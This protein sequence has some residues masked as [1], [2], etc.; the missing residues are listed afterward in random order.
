MTTFIIGGGCFWCIDAVFRR[1]KG[2]TLVES[3]Y[4]NGNDGLEPNYYRVAAG[5]TGFA[6]VVR[7]TFDESTI[8]GDTILDIFFLIHD[9]TTLNRQGADVGTQYRSA[10][11]Y[12]DENQKRSFEAAVK[13]AETVWDD[14]IL[15]EISPLENFFVAEDEH[16]DFFSKQ[17]ESG[18]CSIVIMPKIIKARAAYSEWFD[19]EGVS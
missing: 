15:T 6:E 19:K 5:R 14:P 17:P 3:G 13:R 12:S 16:Q 18:Y 10:L 11:L 8:P 4:A 2:V 1:I 9:P 7:L